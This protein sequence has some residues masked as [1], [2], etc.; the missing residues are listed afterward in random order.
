MGA[1]LMG[2]YDTI[3][4]EYL[5]PRGEDCK[6]LANLDFNKDLIYQT[7]DLD[8]CLSHYEIRADGT[9]WRRHDEGWIQ[10][11]YYT[12]NVIFYDFHSDDNLEN[13]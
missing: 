3:R 4:C 11:A 7:K 5:L 10:L 13:D 1:R 2:M 9:L 8:C 6:E 12:G